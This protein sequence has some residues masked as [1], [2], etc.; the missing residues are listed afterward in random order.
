MTALPIY[1]STLET[2]QKVI[3]VQMRN[4]QFCLVVDHII[5]QEEVV[6]KPLGT[7]LYSTPGFSGATITGDGGI[8]LILDIPSLMNA[9]ASGY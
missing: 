2:D 8:A 9:Y 7:M 4:Q 1:L 6:I 5:G 3:V